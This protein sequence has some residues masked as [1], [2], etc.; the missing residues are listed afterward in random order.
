MGCNG[1]LPRIPRPIKYYGMEASS[2]SGKG[3]VL[4]ADGWFTP[5]PGRRLVFRYAVPLVLFYLAV[6]AAGWAHAGPLT[7]LFLF[8]VP[9][10]ALTWLL[11]RDV[12]GPLGEIV[13]GAAEMAK[14]DLDRRLMVDGRFGMGDLA[15]S[16]NILGGRLRKARRRMAEEADLSRAILNSMA[17]GVVAVDR[18][19][20]VRLLNPAVERTFG[21]TERA[22]LGKSVVGAVRHHEFERL[23]ADVL[24]GGQDIV[25]ELSMLAPRPRSFLVH[26]TPL[27]GGRG[28][29]V[30][31]LRDVT[32]TRRLERIRSDFFANVSHE[33]RTP[34]TSI[35]G[36][37][38]TMLDGPLD[39]TAG[40]R[41]FLEIMNDETE[42][43]GRLI[44]DVFTLSDIENRR[45]AF[46]KE[47]VSVGAII[48]KVE[49]MFFAPAADRGVELRTETAPDL[50]PAW[51]DADMVTQVLINLVDNAVKYTPG[52]GR[53][54]VTA[55]PDDDG[56]VAVRVTDTGV[57]IGSN[58]LP[59]IFERF[60]RVDKA[61]SREQ[62]GTGLGL[63]IVKHIL[64]LLGG[65]IEVVSSP[66]RGSTFTV[67]LPS[68]G[69]GVLGLQLEGPGAR[70]VD[71][72][73]KTGV[74]GSEGMNPT[75]PD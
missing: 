39:D 15:R 5:G 46:K 60:Y 38:E 44:D 2:I 1:C 25:E 64:E 23:I 68:A 66:G 73:Y 40:T 35:K 43:L 32:E 7:G 62:G 55:F 6:V 48:A 70:P 51:G 10:C 27:P 18:D 13:A 47:E 34:L 63:S 36:F 3:V 12:I 56:R 71:P 14:G 75:T 61:R 19:G 59:R 41:H 69:S 31:I 72:C 17:D 4:V 28:G 21:V 20:R 54:L 49:E 52:G 24:A 57:G 45:R 9:A 67:H 37:L 26:L 33:L 65:R 74:S 16:I 30:A 8:I 50:P 58:D 42:R 22:A 11:F 29:A 53:V